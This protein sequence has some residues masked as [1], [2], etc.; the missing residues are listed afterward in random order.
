[1]VKKPGNHD[2]LSNGLAEAM[3]TLSG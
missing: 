2:K 3:V 1:V